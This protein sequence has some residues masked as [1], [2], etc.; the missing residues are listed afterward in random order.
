MHKYSHF[1]AFD[2][3]IILHNSAQTLQ[4]HSYDIWLLRAIRMFHTRLNKTQLAGLREIFTDISEH[5][6]V[7]F[8]HGQEPREVHHV[9]QHHLILFRS[10]LHHSQILQNLIPLFPEFHVGIGFES[11][12][13]GHVGNPCVKLNHHVCAF[14]LRVLVYLHVVVVAENFPVCVWLGQHR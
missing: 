13:L 9:R 11:H 14:R 6:E 8:A 4:T 1:H 7:S 2:L 3:W 5:T 12:F 10:V